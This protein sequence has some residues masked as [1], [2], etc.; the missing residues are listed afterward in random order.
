MPG[1]YTVAMTEHATTIDHAH[2]GDATI[3][4]MHGDITLVEVDAVVTSANESLLGGGGVDG[5]IHRAAGP[6][7]LDECLKIG[8]CETGQAVITTGGLL[9]ARY[10]I[11]TVGPI[12]DGGEQGEAELLASAY[13]NSLRIAEEH[14]VSSVA[15]PSISTGVYGYPIEDAARI[16]LETTLA[17]LRSGST[18]R[19][20]LFVLFTEDD[21]EVYQ[22]TLAAVLATSPD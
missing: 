15:F 9:P 18:L 10:V 7:L 6:R 3:E 11:H 14:Q 20:I 21:L 8:W 2:V 5:A 17:H 1:R 4:L 16:A 13:Q 19:R 12:W 22:Q